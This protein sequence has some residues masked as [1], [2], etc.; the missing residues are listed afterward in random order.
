MSSRAG[1]TTSTLTTSVPC[2]RFSLASVCPGLPAQPSQIEAPARATQPNGLVFPSLE[3]A[4]EV[5]DIR[6]IVMLGSPAGHG[7][8]A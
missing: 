5:T 6:S 8:V 2:C 3:M 7:R 4:F 1:D